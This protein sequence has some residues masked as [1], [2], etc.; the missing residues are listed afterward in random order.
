MERVVDRGGEVEYL[1]D[2]AMKGQWGNVV[3]AYRSS[4]N[5][6]DLCI[7]KMGDTALHIAAFDGE[8]EVVRALLEV[9]K[10][11]VS[12]I[13]QIKNKKGNT[14]LHLAAE[15]GDVVTCHAMATKDRKLVSSRNNKNETPLF[16]AAL[17]GHEKVFR[18]LH[19]HCDDERC[20]SFRARNGDTILHA[21]M[22]G[23]YFSLAFKILLWHPELVN[24][25]NQSG[26]S[27]L[28]I[29]A[30]TP[31]AFKSSSRLRPLDR[32]IYQC[33]IV[34]EL[35]GG[36]K[37]EN[38]ICP[39]EK[40]GRNTIDTGSESHQALTKSW[41]NRMCS[42]LCLAK[43]GNKKEDVENSQ[44]EN[45]SMSG[46][47]QREESHP[48]YIY[49]SCVKFFNLITAALDV[50]N[51]SPRSTIWSI[52]KILD[53]KR[54]HI[55]A[56]QVMNELV[57]HSNLYKK[58]IQSTG[59]TPEDKD[60]FGDVPDPTKVDPEEPSHTEKKDDTE[61]KKNDKLE[62]KKK[63]KDNKLEDKKT[64][65]LIAA[66]M[67]VKEMVE[68]ILEKFPVAIEDVDSE[69]KN[70]AL[71]AVENRQPH[72]YSLLLDRKKEITRLLRRVDNNGNNA[73][74]LAA[75]CGSHRPWLTPG[76]ALQMQWELKWYTFVKNSMPP[77]S[78][79][80]YNKEGQMPQEV[81]TTSHKDLRQEGS[82]WL[83]KTSES[84]S[85]VA[86]LIA[87]V[88][89]ATSASVPGGLDDKTG[90]PVFKDMPAFNAFTIS[91]LLALCLSV[92]ALVFFLT[93]ITSRYEAHDY[94]ISLPRKL[95]LGLTSL[96]ASIAAVLVSFCTGH[97]FLLD[98]QLRY[99]AYPLYAATCLP[100]TIFA[101]AQLS[102]YYDLIRVIF[103]KVPQ[104]SY[105]GM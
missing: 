28:H 63:D 24:Y 40:R 71:L 81:F 104:R 72:V 56:T 74:H 94:S 87:T 42:S 46:M 101:L 64:P 43:R 70:V 10:E 5:V 18:C 45:S 32:L 97:I 50:I 22:S 96:F 29:L 16:L 48:N 90:S 9:I 1:F 105:K 92:T 102:L 51:G 23:E 93:I 66:K 62:E 49:S 69:N 88:A 67:G 99:V 35:T 54:R 12:K 52:D 57:K 85:V 68:T 39:L 7:T 31:S 3:G 15:V 98:R 38:S 30:N 55:W 82:N 4:E 89:F 80:R 78:S 13:L 11:N 61:D 47:N 86:A 73:L 17:N 41:G 53:E 21:A 77:R 33:L 25:I 103:S 76:A 58:V 84:C 60:K 8:T 100:V 14:P 19:S 6:H 91:S 26:F 20:Y 36:K 75:K 44:Q 59:E 27:P 83:V 65:I 2:N 34:E 37:D 95:L 79:V